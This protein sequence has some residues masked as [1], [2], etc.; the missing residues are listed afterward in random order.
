MQYIQLVLVHCVLIF[1][2]KCVVCIGGG[3]GIPLGTRLADLE[4]I[5]TPYTTIGDRTRRR[6]KAIALQ[7]ELA[8]QTTKTLR[9]YVH[10]KS[11]LKFF[12][13]TSLGKGEWCNTEIVIVYI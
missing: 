7:T 5:V 3:N 12:D 8:G 6:W 1:D 4:T 9:W 2:E 10:T 11:C 13:K